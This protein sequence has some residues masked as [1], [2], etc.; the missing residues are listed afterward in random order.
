LRNR[1]YLGTT[2]LK[3]SDDELVITKPRFHAGQEVE[4]YFQFSAYNNDSGN[5]Q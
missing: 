5:R 3:R 4:L 2:L 1:R